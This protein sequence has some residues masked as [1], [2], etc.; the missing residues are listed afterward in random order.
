MSHHE[1]SKSLAV[2]VD[3]SSAKEKDSTPPALTF[4][5]SFWERG[6]PQKALK[7]DVCRTP[8]QMEQQVRIVHHYSGRT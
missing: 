7:L 8:K 1:K 4:E 2:P 5:A 3:A 6:M